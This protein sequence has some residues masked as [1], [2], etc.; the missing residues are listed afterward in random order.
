MEHVVPQ[1]ATPMVHHEDGGCLRPP[2]GNLQWCV[3]RAEEG[4]VAIAGGWS[5]HRHAVPAPLSRTDAAEHGRAG[6]PAMCGA[7]RAFR[8][9]GFAA[10]FLGRD[11]FSRFWLSDL[12][13]F[14]LLLALVRESS[15]LRHGEPGSFALGGLAARSRMSVARVA[16]LLELGCAGGDFLRCRDPRD[17]RQF[18]L[19]PAAATQQTVRELAADFFA[20][21]AAFLGRDDPFPRLAPIAQDRAIAAF[22]DM[23]LSRLA[24]CHMEDRAGGSLTF[25][26]AMLDL[27]LHGPLVPSDFVR[28]EALRLRVTAMTLR[29]I[30]YRAEA[31]G[32]VRRVGRVLAPTGTADE[33]VAHVRQELA[34]ACAALLGRVPATAV[35]LH[36]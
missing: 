27:Q 29:N 14:V 3:A 15:W 21:A 12:R 8:E 22:A 7:L 20:A 35:T 36:G 34:A 11:A 26:M 28:R 1:T 2:Q 16:K 31:R 13:R 24:A 9:S 23:V 10:R 18:V 30:L 33:R 19:E 25:L 17:G 5:G 32:W 4:V 6:H